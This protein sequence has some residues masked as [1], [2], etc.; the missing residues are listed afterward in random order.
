M[1]AVDTIVP[2]DVTA[3]RRAVTLSRFVR[4]RE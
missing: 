3:N 1:S 4:M 2:G